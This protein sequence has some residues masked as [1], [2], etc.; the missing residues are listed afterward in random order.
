[1][2]LRYAFPALAVA[3]TVLFGALTTTSVFAQS[4][5][6]TYNPAN[7]G[8]SIYQESNDGASA[9]GMSMDKAAAPLTIPQAFNKP[10]IDGVLTPGE[11]DDAVVVVPGTVVTPGTKI[12][13]KNDACYLYIAADLACNPVYY[14]N[15]NMMN[16]WFDV[17]A[18]GQ[19]DGINDGNLALPAPGYLYPP[20]VASWGY[21]TLSGWSTCST[22]RLR[23]HYPWSTLGVV[24][25]SSHVM[26]RRINLP[27]NRSIIEARIDYVN[28]P[29]HLTGGVP[30]KIRMQTYSGYYT[31]GGTVQ[32]QS[33]WPTVNGSAYFSGPVPSELGDMQLSTVISAADKFDITSTSVQDN[34]T[35]ASKAFETGTSFTG[36][37]DYNLNLPA[38]QTIDYR[39][40]FYG[41]FPATSLALTYVGSVVVNNPSGT[42]LV[43]VPV[44]LPIGFY[45][46]E[47]EAD[48]PEVCGIEPRMNSNNILL[49]GPGQIPCSVFPG[50]VNT[51]G[52]V[53]YSDKKALTDYIHDANLNPSMLSG[54]YRL[55]PRYPTPLAEVEFTGQAA[56]PWNT[57]DGCHMDTDGNGTINTF[58]NIAIKLNW[59]KSY[60]MNAPKTKD[61][62][63]VSNFDMAQNYPNPFNPSTSIQYNAPEQS[64][65]TL[66]VS[67][68]LGRTVA[69]L[70]NGTVAAGVHSAAL[71]AKD[72]TSGQYIATI[73]MTGTESG[74]SFSKSIKMTLSK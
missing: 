32:I 55:A 60:N 28:S 48:D 7:P 70:V 66:I 45:T 13:M 30:F 38:P 40:R 50:D 56:L 41:P 65:V 11:W 21:N 20:D 23:F 37:I 64:N 61:A 74:L 31:G 63:S 17:N 24:P 29:I 33:Q 27:P 22:C 44:N 47:L 69:T 15:A 62:F 36:E 2:R 26:V 57:V 54:Y 34:P 42:A 3:V 16:L 53:N 19:W 12:Y 46:V 14:G 39:A 8:Q 43:N 71:D 9:S 35:F 59:F 72:L 1:M 73:K 10:T 51:D 49:L 6:V 67:D 4:T 18:N 52:I 68:V 5:I 25:S 58:D